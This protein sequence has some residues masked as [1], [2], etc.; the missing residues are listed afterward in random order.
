MKK[1]G[2]DTNVLVR[3]LTQDDEKQFNAACRII[4]D[5]EAG[6]SF[7]LSS[8]VLCEL[9]WVLESAYGYLRGEIVDALEKIM[10]TGQFEIRDKYLMRKALDDYRNK[11][12][13]FADYYL[14]HRNCADG[15]RKTM[16]FDKTLDHSE[17]F[18]FIKAL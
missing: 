17:L 11:K 10:A 14:G 15:A 1:S 18:S 6:S 3:Y 8:I 4:D 9:V 13:D 2:L 16:T 5:A 12:G 7:I